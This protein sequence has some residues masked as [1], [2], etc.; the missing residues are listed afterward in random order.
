MSGDA[1]QRTPAAVAVHATALVVG[2]AGV[3]IRG[4]SGAGKSSLAEAI[5]AEAALRGRFARLVGDDSVRLA[6]AGGR[7]LARPHPRIVGLIE[8]R[9]AGLARVASEPA[10]VVRLVI[11][12]GGPDEPDRIPAEK[13]KR[14]ALHGVSL[15][16][17]RLRTGLPPQEAARR[18]LL[19]LDS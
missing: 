7:L 5:L 19:A 9:G 3:L 17:L 11:D 13:D 8:R 12:L 6:A 10:A 2:E 4:R 18:A 1:P 15:P 16:R 14:A